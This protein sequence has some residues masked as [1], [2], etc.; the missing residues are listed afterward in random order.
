MHFFNPVAVM[1]LVELVR[2]P[3]TDDVDARDRAGS[4]RRG[5]ASAACSCGDAPAFVVNRVL[6]RMT[7]RAHAGARA[8]QHGRRD[9]RG[10]TPPR[11]CRWRRRCSSDGRPARRQPRPRDAARGLPGP[12][13]ALADARRL[14]GRARRDRRRAARAD[15]PST[16]SPTA[17]LDALADEIAHVLAEGVV[18][19]AAD[20]DACLLLGAGFPFLLGGI[21]KHLDQKGVSERVLGRPLADWAIPCTGRWSCPTAADQLFVRAARPC[22]SEHATVGAAAFDEAARQAV[23]HACK[24]RSLQPASIGG[25]REPRAPPPSAPSLVRR[26][27]PPSRRGSRGGPRAGH[28]PPLALDDALEEIEA[29]RSAVAAAGGPLRPDARSR[30]RARRRSRRTSPPAPSCAATRSTRWPGCSPS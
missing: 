17:V 25:G 16:R 23:P 5:W 18:A 24:K 15:E 6:T 2:T 11:D 9:G 27:V 13:P 29:G 4:R 28:R 22:P 3:A 21:T 8:R 12:L 1:P 19:E 10:G 30:A 14:R 26:A 7:T 20:V